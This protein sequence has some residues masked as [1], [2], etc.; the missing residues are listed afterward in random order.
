MSVTK[1][2][3]ADKYLTEIQTSANLL[4][5]FVQLAATQGTTLYDVEKNVLDQ[6]LRIGYLALNALLAL[7]GIGDLG[8]KVTTAE[9][10]TLQ[11]SEEPQSRPLR[12]IFGEHAFEQFVYSR[13]EHRAIELRPIDARLSLSSRVCSNL[14]EEFSQLF[15]IDTAFGQS[16]RNLETV[17]GQKLS[18]NTLEAISQ[19]MGDDAKSFSEA[20]P[21]PPASEEAELFVA[22]LDA[23]GVPLIQPEPAKVKAFET[24]KLRPGNR[25]MATL[26]GA[27]SVDRFVRTPAEI[28]AALFRDE[29]EKELENAANN[30]RAKRPA[31]QYK[32]LSVHFPEVY[33]DGDATLTSTGAFETCCWL[34][35]EIETRRQQ[36]QPLLLLGDGDHRQWATAAEIL[37][38]DRVEIL[39]IVHVSSYVWQAANVFCTTTAER[40]T[41]TR[42]RLTTILE[43]GVKSVIRSLRCL[44]TARNLRGEERKNIA[45]IANYFE[46]H[47]ERMKYDEYLAAGYPIA[48]GVIEGACR[49]LVK[50]RMERSGMRWTLRGAKTMLNVRAVRESGYWNEFHTDR[51]EKACQQN[52]P[53]R[54]LLSN[55]HPFTLAS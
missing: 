31:P 7:Q 43:G 41:F 34:G 5:Q 24:R 26:G 9:G 11:R 30:E 35:Q 25:R 13:G 19:H 27:Y 38:A 1:D 22:T 16:A 53:H 12:T 36:N 17:F 47:A 21:T 28:V 44:S 14:L 45:R 37:P 4:V 23:K 29:L 2:S 51:R 6:V 39:D 15:C 46:A 48:T 10:K 55:Y 40:E 33:E 18:V 3:T 52:H 49:H 50:D 8:E 54:H 42:T 20:L 32:H